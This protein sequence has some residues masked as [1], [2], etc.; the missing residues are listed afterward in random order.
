MHTLPLNT[1]RKLPLNPAILGFFD[2][3][4]TANVC[5]SRCFAKSDQKSGENDAK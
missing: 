3:N 5:G 1:T 4:G 2:G